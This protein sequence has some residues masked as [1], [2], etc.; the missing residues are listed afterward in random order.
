MALIACS[1]MYNVAPGSAAAWGEL[2]RWLADASGVPMK[3]I[4]HRFPESLEA[5]WSRPDLGAAFMCGRP[6]AL[7]RPQPV[8][9]AAPIPV[10]PAYQG[11]PVYRTHFIVRDEAP[12]RTVSETFGTRIGWTV[13]SSQSGYHAVV[14]HLL[15]T[16]GKDW[17]TLY[18][19]RIGP[20]YHPNGV[21]EAIL[22]NRIDV[23]PLDSYA[24]DLLR[25]H[26]PERIHPLRIL[27]S[28]GSTPMPLLIASPGIEAAGLIALRSAFLGCTTDPEVAPVLER[29]SLL[30][31][32]EIRAENYRM[33]TA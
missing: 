17:Q 23:G 8:P 12:Y 31:F 13:E 20:L 22:G 1:R 3:I 4:E 16:Y 6:F 24:F 19:Q 14:Q 7:A 29:L 21:I 27:E 32:A 33:L 28:T 5:L 25:L 30:G 10:G 9:I 2:F 26:A 11:R 18:P 15:K